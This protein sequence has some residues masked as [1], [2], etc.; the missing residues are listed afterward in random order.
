MFKKLF[1]LVAFIA[2][3]AF[4]NANTIHVKVLDSNLDTLTK[5]KIKYFVDGYLLVKD[6]VQLTSLNKNQIQFNTGNYFGYAEF[7]LSS[8]KNAIGF[9]INPSETKMEISFSIDDFKK[10]KISIQNSRDNLIYTKLLEYKR[11]FDKTIGELKFKR[12]TQSRFDSL[13]LNKLLQHENS[14][15]KNYN[16]MNVV[17]DSVLKFDTLLYTAIIADFLKTPTGAYF[18]KLRKDFDN[19]DALL[20]WHYFDFIDFSNPLI[21]NH[22]ALTIKINEYFSWYT[23]NNNISQKEGIDMIMKK[24]ESN[25]QVHNFL[26]NHLLEYFL[27]LNLDDA[28]KY[29][30]DKYADGCGLQLSTQKMKEIGGII[31]T[32][33]NSKIPDIVA[34]DSK[35]EIRSLLN[36][37]SKNKYTLVYVWTSWCHACQTKTPKIVEITNPFLKKGLSVFSIS[38]DDKKDNWLSAIL[39][40]R[41]ESWTNTSELVPIQNSNAI[42]KL[43]IRTTPKIYIVDKNGIIV[44]KDIFGDD[45]Q[46]KLS[47]LLK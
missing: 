40:Y 29:I 32:N 33:V 47:E 1:A 28:V 3:I 10:D 30:Y 18:P 11:K 8:S 17:C 2:V 46:K 36:V 43:N 20:H 23:F 19:Y 4:A 12:D 13:F 5:L 6:S 26:F 37:A 16:L 24:A 21:L 27:N 38:L 15:E 22:P 42:L 14:V 7:E 44:A 35:G 39:K 34:N 9:I 41:I 45:L 25:H 31:Y